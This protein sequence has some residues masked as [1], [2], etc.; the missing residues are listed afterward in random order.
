MTLFKTS[1]FVDGQLG[2][3]DTIEY[4]GGFWLV[5]RWRAAPT[6]GYRMPVRIVRLDVLPY[7]KLGPPQPADF[8]LNVPIPKDVLDGTVPSNKVHGYVVIDHPPIEY[9][10]PTRH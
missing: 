1:A 8:G 2:L 7:Q 4:E 9:P 10:I 3:V 6:A 5:L